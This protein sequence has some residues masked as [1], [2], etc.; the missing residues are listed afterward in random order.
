MRKGIRVFLALLLVC[1]AACALCEGADG[2]T[3]VSESGRIRLYANP[4]TG[5]ILVEDL[6]DG[7]VWR[8]NPEE[9][10]GR[11]VHK[12]T[13][14]SQVTI[15]YTSDRGTALTAMG[16]MDSVQKN[17]FSMTVRDGEIISTYDFPKL[18]IRLN[19]HFRLTDGCLEA[20]VPVEE[21]ESYGAN[22]LTSVEVLPSFGAAGRDETGYLLLPDGCGTLIRFNNG[23]TA[24]NEYRA[25]VYGK[26]PSV[27][28]QVGLASSPAVSR[29]YEQTVRLP[30][31]GVSKGDHGFLA[32]I[33]ENDSKAVLHARVSNLTGF[34][35]AYSEFQLRSSGS[36]IMNRKEFEQS[37]TGIVE[38]DGLTS[39]CYTVRY[40]FLNGEEESGYAG[41]ARVYRED[42]EKEKGL[43]RRTEKGDYPLY[44]DVYG[45]IRKTA[46]FL[47]IPYE[48]AY[49]L[50]STESAWQIAEALGVDRVCMRYRQFLSGNAYGK[51]PSSV[52]VQSCLGN[53]EGLR[54]LASRMRENGG[55]LFPDVDMINV[56]RRGNGFRP[57]YDAVLTPVNSPQMQYQILY[58]SSKLDY[59]VAPWYLM[60]PL[61][62]AFFYG[63]YFDSYE[64]LGLEGISLSAIG[65]IL[66]A[67]NR[68]GGIG[69][70]DAE[71]QAAA[72]L[73]EAADRLGEVMI[74]HGNAY[75]AALA[76]HVVRSPGNSSQFL[77]CDEAVPF[78]QMVFHGYVHYSLSPV[79]GSGN[80]D[81]MLLRCL[82]Y[83]ASPLYSFVGENQEELMDSRM[84]EVY[85]ADWRQW[86]DTV[87]EQYGMLREVLAPLADRT[88]TGHAILTPQVRRTDYGDI[89]VYVNYGAET[90]EADG[91]TIPAGGFAVRGGD[92][93]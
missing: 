32:V 45:Y 67:D 4:Q 78:W 51:V 89:S 24:M 62:Y 25:N 46:H 81:E 93:Q 53:T 77:I 49:R 69:R 35:Y 7:Y 6:R 91:V 22:S 86:K 76:A 8:S 31:F 36:I 48:K 13:L 71:E 59:T 10:D 42:L 72:V 60:S 65:D 56:Y 15:G 70:Q 47:G 57:L 34:N 16:Q 20:S 82:E 12:M 80:P 9:A 26:D 63:R 43:I 84:L 64:K 55:A 85:A 44:V 58:A 29:T 68:T 18:E 75:A 39:G 41:M 3:Q 1:L 83:G 21:C 52:R 40:L 74:D 88:M 92:A 11:G 2:F 14:L 54:S 28:G 38:R 79:N 61:K 90:A 30:V 23:V 66:T 27:T 33:T 50:T 73:A 37:V 87:L 17:G 5:E 19:I